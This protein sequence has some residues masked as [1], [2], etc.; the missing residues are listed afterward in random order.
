MK[1]NTEEKTMRMSVWMF[2]TAALLSAA[3]ASAAPN[4]CTGLP[5]NA[6][7]RKALIAARAAESSGLNAQEWAT[8]VNRDG[9][10]CAVAFTGYD[11][12]TQM[13]IGRISSAM[14]ANAGN[15]FA[16]DSSSSSNG[17][18]FAGGLALSTANLY[19]ATQPGG[20]VGELPNNYPVNQ[21]A[22]FSK[23]VELFGT[24]SDPM[25]GQPIGGFMAIG[26]GLGLFA[27][28]QTAVGGLGVAG[29]HSCTDHDIAWRTR[30]LLN[31]DHMNGFPP[32]SGD[33]SRPDNIV[34]D[35]TPNP[36]GGIGTSASGL[37][38]PK[39]PNVGDQTKLPPV[40][41]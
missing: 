13:G 31:F 30:N 3:A 16:F 19:S 9:V 15:T 23:H 28:G 36:A 27:A 29:D 7:L 12:T 32:L 34:Y 1:S 21:A 14:R 2:G 37:G 22:V 24:S 41:Y 26:G 11:A 10:V 33:P 17:A 40:K 39:C 6:Q 25:I 8:I 4:G 38:H 35:I 20:F 5:D 18:G